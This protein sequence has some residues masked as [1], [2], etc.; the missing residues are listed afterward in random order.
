MTCVNVE[1]RVFESARP[2]TLGTLDVTELSLGR[3]VQRTV[4]RGGLSSVG[5]ALVMVLPLLHA[6]GILSLLIGV[7][8]IAWLTWRTSVLVQGTQ[9]IECPACRQAIEIKANS[10]GWPVRIQCLSCGV[11]VVARPPTSFAR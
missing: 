5:F 10:G 9:R 11:G 4:V 2:P 3:R 8:L 7:P 1:F 6:C